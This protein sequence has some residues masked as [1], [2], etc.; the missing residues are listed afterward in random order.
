M[1]PITLNNKLLSTPINS[2]YKFVFFF[3]LICYFIW[4]DI[5]LFINLQRWH[6]P[7]I[8]E[9]PSKITLI[10]NNIPQ[11]DEGNQLYSGNEIDNFGFSNKNRSKFSHPTSLPVEA[12]TVF[13]PLSVKLIMVDHATHYVHD[14]LARFIEDVLKFSILLPWMSANLVSYLGLLM[15]IFASRLII[16]DNPTHMR[17]AAVLFELRN[18]A[19]SLD[20]C[21]FRS[22]T[23]RQSLLQANNVYQSN[24][25]SY[26]YNVDK[27]CD[28]FAGLFFCIAILV[29]FLRH[30]PNKSK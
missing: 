15:A 3:V 1:P 12:F 7:S 25:G 27:L 26:G 6:H 23:R 14:V 4:M 5:A 29:K 10:S 20:G 28:G 13:K 11:V 30:L 17:I 19:D 2:N 24:Y 21:V 16:T 9:T 18:L 22:V 8:I